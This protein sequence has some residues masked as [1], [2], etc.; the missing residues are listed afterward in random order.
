LPFH[1]KLNYGD[2]DDNDVKLSKEG[3]DFSDICVGNDTKTCFSILWKYYKQKKRKFSKPRAT[4][5]RLK[6]I[7]YYYD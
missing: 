3:V 5:S 2:N 1:K 6:I 4:L 7:E